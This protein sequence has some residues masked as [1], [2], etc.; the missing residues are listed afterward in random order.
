MTKEGM[1]VISILNNAFK[2]KNSFFFQKL[3]IQTPFDIQLFFAG[4][5]LLMFDTTRVTLFIGKK[6]VLKKKMHQGKLIK[7][8]M[9][10]A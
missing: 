9:H 3:G 5:L 2:R 7:K 1:T 10:Q 4:G 8:K 6:K